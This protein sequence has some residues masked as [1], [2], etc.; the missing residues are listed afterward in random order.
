MYNNAIY[1]TTG[2]IP[3]FANYG[4]NPILIREPW[5]KVPTAEEA[6]EIVDTID[7]LRTQLLRDIKFM[8]L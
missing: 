6:A 8:N 3:F 2:E 1:L 4:Y 7:Y 5:N